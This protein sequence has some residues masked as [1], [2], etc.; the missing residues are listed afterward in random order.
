MKTYKITRVD[1]VV[2]L[3]CNGVEMLPES[4]IFDCGCGSA[5]ALNL[6]KVIIADCM[7]KWESSKHFLELKWYIVNPA[8]REGFEI[9]DDKV[10]YLCEEWNKESFKKA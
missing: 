7:G 4:G 8:P 10:R 3:F 2:H 5:G 6:A 9:T 1:D